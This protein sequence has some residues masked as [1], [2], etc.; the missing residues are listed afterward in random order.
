MTYWHRKRVLITGAH[1]FLG[2]HVVNRFHRLNLPTYHLDT[3]RRHALDFRFNGDCYRAVRNQDVVIH[4]AGRT[5]GIGLNHRIPGQMFY[6]N[7]LMGLQ[8]MEAA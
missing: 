7:A 6:E 1:G 8:L 3:P 2:H 5:G 4:L